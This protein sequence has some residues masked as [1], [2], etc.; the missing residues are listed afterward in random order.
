[1]EDNKNNSS[2]SYTYSAGEIK[3]ARSIRDK[4]AERDKELSAVELMRRL[5]A[6]VEN[7]ARAISLSLG[8]IGTLILGTGMSIIMTEI[9]N[10]LGSLALPL[11]LL[12]GLVGIG[13]DALA[14][15]VYTAVIKKERRRIAPEMLK[16]A[17]IVEGRSRE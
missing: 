2:F 17:D 6:S 3:E 13:I 1:M 15:P 14:Y 10:M 12:I 9:G 5:D 11:G 8:V 7:K 4:Y 16:L